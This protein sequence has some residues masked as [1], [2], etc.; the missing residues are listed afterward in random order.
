[1]PK[2]FAVVEL[3]QPENMDMNSY[4]FTQTVLGG[5]KV[6]FTAGNYDGIQD[7]NDEFWDPEVSEVT[8]LTGYFR[9]NLQY[10]PSYLWGAII[11]YGEGN[12]GDQFNFTGSIAD[13]ERHFYTAIPDISS[14]EGFND[15]ESDEFQETI[16]L[17]YLRPYTDKPDEMQTVMVYLSRATGTTPIE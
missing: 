8:D 11:D 13:A 3:E 10:S 4:E 16:A 12:L 5:A 14:Y 6:L 1:M 2:I 17:T 15:R 9:G 7:Y